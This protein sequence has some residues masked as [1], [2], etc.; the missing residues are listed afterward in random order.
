MYRL[1]NDLNEFDKLIRT[2]KEDDDEPQIKSTDKVDYGDDDVN[3][4][5]FGAY[6]K[7]VKNVMNAFRKI[8]MNI[9]DLIADQSTPSELKDYLMELDKDVSKSYMKLYKFAHRVKVRHY[10]NGE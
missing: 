9:E 8:G 7:K 6:V 3:E 10:K 1:A 2:L 4:A 5:D